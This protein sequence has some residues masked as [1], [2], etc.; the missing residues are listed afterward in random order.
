MQP[1][2]LTSHANNKMV[3]ITFMACAAANHPS[4]S[5]PA[6]GTPRWQPQR[7]AVLSSSI[8]PS[9]NNVFEFGIRQAGADGC[10]VQLRRKP[11]TK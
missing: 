7:E 8:D 10:C 6:R 3:P 1:L 5:D 9:G 4:S 2:V 11:D